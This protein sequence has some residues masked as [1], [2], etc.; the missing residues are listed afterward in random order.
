MSDGDGGATLPQL[1]FFFLGLFLLAPSPF[2][3]IQADTDFHDG[4]VDSVEKGAQM[5]RNEP[6]FENAQTSDSPLSY[7][8]VF[9]PS[10]MLVFSFFSGTDF[11]ALL[12]PPMTDFQ[13][14]WGFPFNILYRL[15]S[16][17]LLGWRCRLFLDQPWAFNLLRIARLSVSFPQVTHPPSGPE[18]GASCCPLINWQYLFVLNTDSIYVPVLV[19]PSEQACVQVHVW[20]Q[21]LLVTPCVP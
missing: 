16:L 11:Q 15:N 6:K 9:A 2:L 21:G 1:D 18:P 7:Y 3:K 14:L 4:N 12:L 10:L 8:P 5:E 17:C 13:Q 20:V 19:G